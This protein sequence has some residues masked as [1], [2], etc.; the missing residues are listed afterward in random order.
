MLP[1]Y[2]EAREAGV[3]RKVP[4]GG[5]SQFQTSCAPRGSLRQIGRT[6][7]ASSAST[8]TTRWSTFAMCANHSSRILTTG[9]G[10]RNQVYN[11]EE[12]ASAVERHQQRLARSARVL[13]APMSTTV[14]KE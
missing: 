3:A 13:S 14:R 4:T 2:L 8:M 10:G 5:S 12:S 7:N 6:S 11:P 1:S 9:G